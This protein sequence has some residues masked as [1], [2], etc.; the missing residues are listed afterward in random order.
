MKV[1]VAVVGVGAM[2]RGIVQ[3]VQRSEDMEVVAIADK[4]P[5]ALEKASRFLS[6][7]TLITTNPM[8][9][10]DRKP[11]VLVEAT[12]SIFEAALLV[13]HALENK[14][15]VILMN[16]E[17]DQLYGRLLAKKA[18]ENGV[19]LTSDAGDQHGV[20]LR[21]IDDV[22]SMGFEIVMAGNNKGFL[23]RYANSE[24]I[25]EEA[26]KRRLTPKQCAAYTDGTKLAIEMALVAN[27]VNLN[28]L[29]DGMVGPRTE[30]VYDALNVFDLEQA[31]QVGGVVDYV[32]G[33]KPG[34]SVFVIGYSDDP[35]DRFYMN[36]YKMGEGPY[37]LFLRPYHLCH[38]ETPI[39]IKRVMK[40]REPILI[41][42]KRVLEV[43]AHAKMDLEPGTKLDGIGGYHLYGLLEKPGNLPI[44]LSEGA[45]LIR[46]KKKDEPI[47]WDDVEFPE[48][49][50]R[51]ALWEEQKRYE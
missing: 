12:T 45:T 3:V 51:I 49:D 33:A 4:N 37:Y 40:Y 16:A 34:G 8:E 26:A 42:K 48:D 1:Q 32:L 23:N 20:L 47:G 24:S 31:R 2:G 17:V 13:Q 28:L 10:I 36:Y 21:L 6:S 43:V 41:Q 5:K 30:N 39:A 14:I 38:F 11:D 29:Q 7:D 22:K 35:E 25:K 15:H 46:R 19:I 44:G 27:A 50:P 18:E 9:V